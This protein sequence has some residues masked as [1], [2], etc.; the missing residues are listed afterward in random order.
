MLLQVT[1]GGLKQLHLLSSFGQFR[2]E[3]RMRNGYQLQSALFDGFAVQLRHA[4]FRHDVVHLV[5]ARRDGC[6]LRQHGGDA[7]HGV[8]FGGGGQYD[9]G[10]AAFRA[11]GSPYKV[12]L[13]TG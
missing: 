5:F 4:I 9:E 10:F 12:S 1:E 3:V 11:I 6:T 7:R 8:V 13:P 2:P